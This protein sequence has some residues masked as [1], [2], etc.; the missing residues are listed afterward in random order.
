MLHENQDAPL[1]RARSISNRNINLSDWRG[2]KVLVKFHRF[3]GCPIAQRQLHEWMKEQGVLNGAGIETIVFLHSSPEKI[4]P[5]YH[6]VP[7]MYIISD[8]EKKFYRSYQVEFSWKK[9]LSWATW[10][11]TLGA[12][13]KGYF[14]QFSK[15]EG[16][17]IGVPADFLVDEQGRIK[18]VHY[19][20]H[21]GD[22][23]TVAQVYGN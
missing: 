22:S 1:I 6:E 17:I 5:V 16:G 8:K 7:G 18:M 3:S 10:R 23:W 12:I 4:M 9:M 14:P 15:F 19:G 20:R 2:K 11:E 13:F 21:F